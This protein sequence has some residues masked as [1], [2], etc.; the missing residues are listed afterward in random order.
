MKR[1]VIH[2][3]GVSLDGVYMKCDVEQGLLELGFLACLLRTGM[4]L[5]AAV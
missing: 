2:E 3:D 1:E 4:G 5:M